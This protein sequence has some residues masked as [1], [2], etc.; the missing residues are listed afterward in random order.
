[1]KK[2]SFLTV[3]LCIIGLMISPQASNAELAK[4]ST[5]ELASITGQAGISY[6]G[7]SIGLNMEN[8]LVFFT[9]EDGVN[10]ANNSGS[11]SLTE[12]Y[13]DSTIS[14]KAGFQI[15]AASSNATFGNRIEGISFSVEN[16]S[17]NINSFHSNVKLGPTPGTGESLG[18][19]GIRNMRV[20]TTGSVRV[21]VN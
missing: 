1:M 10:G 3:A 11:L 4:L 17:I 16:P 6:T 13:L 7:G 19:I 12:T 20:T 2:L 18:I 21:R 5:A 14:S 8:G 15:E 9:D